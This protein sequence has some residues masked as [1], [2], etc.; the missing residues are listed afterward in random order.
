MVLFR[1]SVGWGFE[2]DVLLPVLVVVSWLEWMAVG[3]GVALRT[4]GTLDSIWALI[5]KRPCKPRSIVRERDS[6]DTIS[7]FLTA[8]F[9]K[10]VMSVV[11]IM[12]LVGDEMLN[13]IWFSVDV[14]CC[15]A[16]WAGVG[17]M[18]STAVWIW[19][20]TPDWLVRRLFAGSSYTIDIQ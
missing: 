9:K 15:G 13:K 17:N 16:D 10:S 18:L 19:P 20:P 6:W 2:V 3:K 8:F 7:P 1:Q 11:E 12:P 5:S 14:S 4:L